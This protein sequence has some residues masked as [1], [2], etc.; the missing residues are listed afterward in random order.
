E[1]NGQ[2][3]RGYIQQ[4]YTIEEWRIESGTF[5]KLRELSISYH[6][7]KVNKFCS[8][9]TASFSGRNLYSWDTYQGYD[10]ETNATGQ[11]SLL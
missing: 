7:G 1:H 3:P 5:T 11:S 4:T 6:F 9:L 2:L 10:P 8:D